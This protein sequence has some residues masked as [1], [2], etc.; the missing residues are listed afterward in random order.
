MFGEPIKQLVTK[1]G[2]VVGS[3]QREGIALSIPSGAI[4]SDLEFQI[5]CCINCPLKLPEG[6]TPASPVYFIKHEGSVQFHQNIAVELL[7]FIGLDSSNDCRRLAFM[8]LESPRKD[9]TSVFLFTKITQSE[10]CF[11]PKSQVGKILLSHFCPI[12]VAQKSEETG[13]QRGT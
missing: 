9:L 7:H 11:E 12:L 8:T 6:Y 10:G 2:G 13:R 1:A 4:N 5:Q 3:L